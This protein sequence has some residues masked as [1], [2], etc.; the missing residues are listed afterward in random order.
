MQKAQAEGIISRHLRVYMSLQVHFSLS[1]SV[2]VEATI[3]SSFYQDRRCEGNIAQVHTFVNGI[4][5]L[6]LYLYR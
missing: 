1:S 6:L 2:C 4:A 5:G 3:V